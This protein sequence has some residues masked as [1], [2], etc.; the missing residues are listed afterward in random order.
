M[1]RSLHGGLAHP[2]CG[3]DAHRA[4]LAL[5]VRLR[6]AP[7]TRA[8]LELLPD[9]EHGA[10]L[11]KALNPAAVGSQTVLQDWNSGMPSAASSWR[12]W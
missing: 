6:T 3:A 11:G 12:N 9:V 8:G 2:E 1:N 4:A 5:T 10:D 7:R